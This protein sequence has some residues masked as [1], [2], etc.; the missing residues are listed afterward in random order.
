M[1]S[2]LLTSS[3]K[4]RPVFVKVPHAAGCVS[5][6]VQAA[7]WLGIVWAPPS[8]SRRHTLRKPQVGS[9]TGAWSPPAQRARSEVT[10]P[11]ALPAGLP[12]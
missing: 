8:G 7:V 6:R 10:C 12:L 3:G 2:S 9:Q 4:S 1:Q 5:V 11:S